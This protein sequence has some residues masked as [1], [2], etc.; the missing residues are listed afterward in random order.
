MEISNIRKCSDITQELIK[1]VAGAADARDLLEL[2]EHVERISKPNEKA[3]VALLLLARAVLS[4]PWLRGQHLVVTIAPVQDGV[5][6]G[7]ERRRGDGQSNRRV[8][9]TYVLKAPF[10]EFKSV[11]EKLKA[12]PGLTLVQ[13][14]KPIGDSADILTTLAI[15]IAPK[16]H[17]SLR[18][19]GKPKNPSLRPPKKQ[20]LR[21]KAAGGRKSLKPRP[22]PAV[23]RPP[24][25][26]SALRPAG[27]PRIDPPDP[28]P[29]SSDPDLD[30]IDKDWC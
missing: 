22:M 17:A 29:S 2:L 9:R 15:S 12:Q 8:G 13:T 4:A 28:E 11:I 30:S 24:E 25:E 21:P 10:A 1:S 26:R 18:P 23:V 19:P 5:Q 7:L 14:E 16:T 20:S 27:L 6:I 3:G